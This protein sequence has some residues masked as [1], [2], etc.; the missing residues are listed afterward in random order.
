MEIERGVKIEGYEGDW[1]AG[2]S[3]GPR[4]MERLPAYTDEE[5]LQGLGDVSDEI[6]RVFRRQPNQ[7]GSEQDLVSSGTA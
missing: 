5:L 2:L 1:E 7:Q 3:S 4:S 6:E